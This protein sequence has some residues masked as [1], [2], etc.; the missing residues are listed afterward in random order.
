MIRFIPIAASLAL[1]VA[2]LA[3]LGAA[4]ARADADA[5]VCATTYSQG[6]AVTLCNFYNYAQCQATISGRGGS[7]SDNPSLRDSY[8]RS[9]SR[10]RSRS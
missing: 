1:A 8:N 10:I 6:G 5:P 4:P 3:T 7:C 2:A 9:A